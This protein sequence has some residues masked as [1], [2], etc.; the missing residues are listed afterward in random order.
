MKSEI[1]GVQKSEGLDVAG[2]GKIANAIPKEVYERT[3]VTLLTT[4]EKLVAPITETTSGFGRY[5]HQKFENMVEVEKALATYTIEKAIFR[6]KAKCER[7][8]VKMHSPNHTKSFVKAIEEASKETDPLLHEMWSNLLASQ[9]TNH[10]CHPHFV[11]VLPHFGPA[12]AKIL[13]SLLPKS[14]VGEN[15]G[16]YLLYESDSF[17][18]WIPKNEGELNPWTLSCELLLEF[19]FADLLAPKQEELR[20]VAILHRTGSGEAFL[21]AVTSPQDT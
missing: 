20:N 1:P 8:G 6:A 2:F 5:L 16:G 12:E 18:H 19:R 15:N 17:T 13:V 14:A 3:T 4:F 21:E 11:E 7:L 9:L 10:D